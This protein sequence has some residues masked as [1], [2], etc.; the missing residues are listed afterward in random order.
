[1]RSKIAHIKFVG[2]WTQRWGSYVDFVGG[3]LF[4]AVGS[5]SEGSK[6]SG[7]DLCMWKILCF[8]EVFFLKPIMKF[9]SNTVL[10]MLCIPQENEYK[11]TSATWF[12]LINLHSW[13]KL[14]KVTSLLYK[15]VRYNLCYN[16]HNISIYNM[17][18]LSCTQ[19]DILGLTV[20]SKYIS[21]SIQL[22]SLVKRWTMSRTRW[23]CWEGGDL[24]VET[25]RVGDVLVYLEPTGTPIS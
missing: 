8:I 11:K 14:L 16:Y 7:Y 1:M 18:Y 23:F 3:Y 12:N 25:P 10:N 22:D 13:R 17:L 6:A 4:N 15:N 9:G 19:V 2:S 20:M 5:R 24:R 21:N